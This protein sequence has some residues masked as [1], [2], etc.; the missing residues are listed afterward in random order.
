MKPNVILNVAKRSE[1]S[2]LPQIPASSQWC[3]DPSIAC[4]LTQDDIGLD[5]RMTSGDGI[6]FLTGRRAVVLRALTD[7]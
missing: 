5:F 1:R 3:G 7:H 6:L 4:W 2:A